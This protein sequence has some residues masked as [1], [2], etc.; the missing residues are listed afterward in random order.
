MNLYYGK[1]KSQCSLDINVLYDKYRK[2]KKE[3]YEY[4]LDYEEVNEKKH[5]T[6][7]ECKKYRDYLNTKTDLLA[8]FKEILSGNNFEKCPNSDGENLKC[9]PNVILAELSRINDTSETKIDIPDESSK[10]FLGLSKKNTATAAS[11][12]GVSLLGLTLFKVKINFIYQF[13]Y[14][15]VLLILCYH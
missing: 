3:F 12:A 13:E 11:V 2:A 1:N 5:L 14:Q 9:N 6:D 4:C 7:Y 15:V 8:H 10:L